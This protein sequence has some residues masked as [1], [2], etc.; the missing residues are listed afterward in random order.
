VK[1]RP[2]KKPPAVSTPVALAA[3]VPVTQNPAMKD[4]AVA[5]APKKLCAVREKKLSGP[6]QLFFEFFTLKNRKELVYISLFFRKLSNNRLK[7]C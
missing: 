3:N 1:P 4:P 6:G 5:A 2:K 7:I